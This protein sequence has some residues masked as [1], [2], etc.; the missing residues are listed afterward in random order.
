MVMLLVANNNGGGE[1]FCYTSKMLAAI[2]VPF[3]PS[4]NTYYRT[5]KVGNSCRVVLSKKG[6]DYKKQVAEI[7]EKMRNEDDVFKNSIPVAVR[8]SVSVILNAPTRR[9]YDIDNRAKSLLDSLEYA[10][11]YLDDEQ[12]DCLTLRRGEV[13]KG[14]SAVVIIRE[15]FPRSTFE[16]V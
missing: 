12:I 15:K 8:L 14:G 7:V 10:G 9:K 6:R 4:A 13:Q 5:F 16:K 3:P 1:F 2:I 11:I